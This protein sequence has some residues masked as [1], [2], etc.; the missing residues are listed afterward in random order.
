LTFPASLSDGTAPSPLIPSAK[1][2]VPPEQKAEAAGRSS[3]L[4]RLVPAVLIGVSWSNDK[5][6]VR[7][8]SPPHSAFGGVTVRRA[9]ATRDRGQEKNRNCD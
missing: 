9:A 8:R 2:E 3:G 6:V 1:D 4:V 7:T 5:V